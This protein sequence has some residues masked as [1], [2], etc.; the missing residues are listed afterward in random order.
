GSEVFL[1]EN[2]EDYLNSRL[3]INNEDFVIQDIQSQIGKDLRVFVIGKKIIAA[4]LR[5]NNN[6]FCAKFKIGGSAFLYHLT[7]D[8]VEMINKI[9][10]HFDFGLVAIEFLIYKLKIK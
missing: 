6:D 5:V 7:I 8:E 3:K 2:N 9:I 4:V 10:N 1:I